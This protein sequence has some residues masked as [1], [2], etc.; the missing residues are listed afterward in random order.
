MSMHCTINDRSSG[1]TLIE[2]LIYIA[3][4]ALIVLGAFSSISMIQTSSE[5]SRSEA[6][7]IE[8][9]AFIGDRLQTLLEAS[10]T[11]VEQDEDLVTSLAG[12]DT[13]VSAISFIHAASDDDPDHILFSFTL[14]AF[15]NPHIQPVT[16]RRAAYLTL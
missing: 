10:S 12:E 5:R 1:F 15:G 9:A 4:F 6:L 3:L 11:R 2:T 8:D 14:R 13:S 16:V 7:L